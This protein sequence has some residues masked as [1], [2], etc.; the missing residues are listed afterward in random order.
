MVL[1][2]QLARWHGN[3][4][5]YTQQLYNSGKNFYGRCKNEPSF[6]SRADRCSYM[7]ETEKH[8]KLNADLV[9]RVSTVQRHGARQIKHENKSKQPFSS[10][11]SKTRGQKTTLNRLRLL[12][13]QTVSELQNLCLRVTIPMQH[14]AK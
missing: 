13:Q 4:L 10:S 3:P 2:R 1:T 6:L 5:G 12:H 8:L 7:R 9:H 14:T 11:S